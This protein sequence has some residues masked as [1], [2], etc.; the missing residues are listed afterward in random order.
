MAGFRLEWRR[1]RGEGA[2]PVF[3]HRLGHASGIVGVARLA[4]TVGD[5]AWRREFRVRR[6]DRDVY[7]DL[8]RI[9]DWVHAGTDLPDPSPLHI[10]RDDLRR[11][12][13][14]DRFLA[15]VR[16]GA[17]RAAAAGVLSRADA[18]TLLRFARSS[19]LRPRL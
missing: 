11:D 7:T 6:G 16:D 8:H 12:L 2:N 10:W 17:E 1:F 14:A 19:V 4:S 3:L 18:D 13:V 15:A 9:Q 5:A